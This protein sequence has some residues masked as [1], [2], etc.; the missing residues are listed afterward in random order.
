MPKRIDD[1]GPCRTGTP[2]RHSIFAAAHLLGTGDRTQPEERTTNEIVTIIE[3]WAGG[4]YDLAPHRDALV[5]GYLDGRAGDTSRVD[6]IM[7][8]C[9]RAP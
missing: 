7:A 4:A 6:P 8:E 2:C 9:E 5:N 1:T 3:S